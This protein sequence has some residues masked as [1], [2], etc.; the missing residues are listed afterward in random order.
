MI[1]KRLHTKGIT[2][3]NRVIV[4]VLL[5]TCSLIVMGWILTE[6]EVTKGG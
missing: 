3:K 4:N 1:H 6:I 2:V 5:T